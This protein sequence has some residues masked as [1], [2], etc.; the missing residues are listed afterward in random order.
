MAYYLTGNREAKLESTTKIDGVTIFEACEKGSMPIVSA[1]LL[2]GID[3]N[4]QE[5]D[6][7][8]AT[9]M[10]YACK[11][12][13]LLLVRFLLDNGASID[14]PS[15]TGETPLMWALAANRPDVVNALLDRHANMHHADDAGHPCAYFGAA[16]APAL[17]CLVHRGL[18]L[19]DVPLND[20]QTL[21]HVTFQHMGNQRH[22]SAWGSVLYLCE[23]GGIDPN[24]QDA[25]GRTALHYACQNN[26]LNGVKALMLK[27]ANSTIRDNNGSTPLDVS[28]TGPEI[29]A[30]VKAFVAEKST[31]KQQKLAQIDHSNYSALDLK[32]VKHFSVAFFLPNSIVAAG[33]YL[34]TIVGIWTLIVFAVGF[35]TVAKFSM[36]QPRRSMATA[37]WFSGA[38]F[39]GSVILFV[40]VF[41]IYK[42]CHENH[43]ALYL[44]WCTTLPM[45]YCYVRAVLA[46]PG[47]VQSTQEGRAEIY[48]CIAKGG[49]GE[50]Q[51]QGFDMV[52]LVRKPLRSK[53]CSKTGQCVSRFDHF[54]V[55]TGNAIGGGNH[56]HFVIY[57]LCQMIAQ[58]DVA[59]ICW[60]YMFTCS[61]KFL[62]AG[63]EPPKGF[64]QWI[65]W[66]FH[67]ADHSMVTFFMLFYNS[68]VFLFVS[69]VVV[70]QLWY[71]TR[72]VT[73]NEVWFTDRYRWMFRLG[74]RAFSMYDVGFWGNLKDFFI[75]GDL[76]AVSYQVPT[77]NPHLTKISKRYAQQ[78]KAQSEA[79]QASG[80]A[81]GGTTE[82][83]GLLEGGEYG[84]HGHSHGGE[85]CDGSAHGHGAHGP[86][87]AMMPG[88]SN[89]DYVSA[90][91]ALP[92]DK[93]EELTI[94][95]GLLAQL[96]RGE[97]PTQ[98][99]NLDAATFERLTTQARSM[100]NHYKQAMANLGGNLLA[101]PTSPTS[102][103]APPATAAQPQGGIAR[104]KAD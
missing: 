5:R 40:K 43:F 30:F 7:Q 93:Q 87:E 19:K 62:P 101:E 83:D 70:V 72:N 47:V 76:C 33:A 81:A 88:A 89:F 10:H 77:M 64:L 61:P 100:H 29:K 65:E 60:S 49:E 2:G 95:Q 75:S 17:H 92:A 99:S 13:D 6:G 27:G 80:R 68:F 38:L 14:A 48:D 23:Q 24:A 32:Q 53:H 84:A 9:P 41:D 3:P 25:S 50:I 55:W 8:R 16:A 15:G 35:V 26:D 103:A 11:S 104:R 51:R 67:D 42:A 73:S 79:A 91:N 46:D 69:S 98:P 34:P 86:A 85:P 74:S 78:L 59:H 44:W 66:M 12:G 102:S 28:R 71:A 57:C 4:V 97:E 20:K 1:F 63:V 21:L 18:V 39:Y 37:G 54:C 82:R 90:I 58:A 52:S 96:I 56:R 22:K 45:F 36:G 31:T 94:V